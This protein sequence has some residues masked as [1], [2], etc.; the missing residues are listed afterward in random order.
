MIISDHNLKL[1]WLD[2]NVSLKAYKE[3]GR[4]LVPCFHSM[5]LPQSVSS[6]Q[7]ISPWVICETILWSSLLKELLYPKLFHIFINYSSCVLICRYSRSAYGGESPIQ[8]VNPPSPAMARSHS[9]ESRA[10]FIW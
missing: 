9:T 10:I 8:C 7:T 4:L 5:L 3:W 6:S 2:T 1:Q